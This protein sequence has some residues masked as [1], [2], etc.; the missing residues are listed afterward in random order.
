MANKNKNPLSIRDINIV[1]IGPEHKEILNTFETDVNE[2][3]DFLVEDALTNQE[4]CI[5]KTYLWFHKPTNR[6]IAY[7]TLMSDSIRV[8][9][10]HLQSY[11]IEQGVPYKS[12]PALKI[13]RLC[14]TKK[15][16]RQGIGTQ[17]TLFS[18]TKAFELNKIAA[19]RF[20]I[21]D[22]KKDAVNFYKRKGFSI[23]RYRKKGTIP[24]YYDMVTIYR[25]FEGRKEKLF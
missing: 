9:G 4:M 1:P 8:Q 10:T 18:M 14:V 21:V 12:L 11:F 19:C 5:S 6:L 7:L 24:M 2:L 3:K 16:E 20:L 17:T 15:Y 23:L 13:G 22:A 25:Y